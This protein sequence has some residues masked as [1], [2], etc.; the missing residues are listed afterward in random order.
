MAIQ[1][2]DASKAVEA[3]ASHIPD[4]LEEMLMWLMGL[5]ASIGLARK[6]IMTGSKDLNVIAADHA[7]RDQITTLH[8]TIHEQQERMRIMGEKLGKLR[9]IE[10]EGAADVAVIGV[11]ISQLEQRTCP[12]VAKDDC[13]ATIPTRKLLEVYAR[14]HTR[15]LAKEAV[16][17]TH[18]LPAPPTPPTRRRAAAA[19]EVAE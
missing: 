17:A 4:K 3:V 19:K 14:I 6:A 12:C 16:F 1:P 15:R 11:W 13:C 7:V 8:E 18:E 5:A 10:L 9:D 2:N